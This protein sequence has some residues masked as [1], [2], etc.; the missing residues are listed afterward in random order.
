MYFFN[1]MTSARHTISGSNFLLG[2]GI[3][4]GAVDRIRRRGINLSSSIIRLFLM[5]WRA[6][7]S[8]IFSYRPASSALE[9]CENRHNSVVILCGGHLR[10]KLNGDNDNNADNE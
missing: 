6:D 2:R 7:L 1:P 10:F 8:L 9:R 4:A 3:T 5:V